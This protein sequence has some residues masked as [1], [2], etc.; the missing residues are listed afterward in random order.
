MTG[1]VFILGPC[2]ACGRVFS[3]N[4]DL[5]PSIP[6]GPGPGGRPEP[7]HP[8]AG[9]RRE[10]VCEACVTRANPLRVANGLDPIEILPGA[11]EAGEV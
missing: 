6:V 1:Y 2:I 7:R 10:P 9:G 3:F 11:Y 8:D 5:V 4:P